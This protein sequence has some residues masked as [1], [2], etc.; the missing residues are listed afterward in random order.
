M[1]SKL[2]IAGLITFL[3]LIFG[4]SYWLP[5]TV[6]HKPVALNEPGNKPQ[7][8]SVN[9]PAFFEPNMGQHD[10]SVRFKA[11][12]S[13]GYSLFLTATEAVYV[14]PEQKQPD[15]QEKNLSTVTDAGPSKAA[16][17]WMKLDGADP[18]SRSEGVDELAGKTNYIL[19]GTHAVSRTNIPTYRGVRMENIYQGIDVVWRGIAANKVQYDFV[20]EPDADPRRIAWKVEGADSVSINE[21][22]DLL[23]ATEFGAI[24]QQKP[25][26]Y[27]ETEGV[28][29]EVASRFVLN[30]DSVGFE[31]GDYDRTKTLVI[32]PSVDLANAAFSTFLGGSSAESAR[33]VA[34]DKVGNVYVTGSTASSGFP[35]TSGVYD[36]SHNSNDDVFVT[37]LNRRADQ[38][39]YST[40]IGGS[41]LDLAHDIYL[42][43]SGSVIIAGWTQSSGYPTTGGAFDTSLGGTTDAFITKLNA[44]GTALVFSTFFGGN[45]L[46]EIKAV[47]ADSSGNIYVTG[48]TY[49][50]AAT[51]PLSGGAYQTTRIGEN[52][53]FVSK[54]NSSGTSLTYSTL[55]GGNAH[56]NGAND[57]VV[58]SSGNAYIVGSHLPDSTPF[59]TPFPTTGGAYDTTANGDIDAYV[60]KF[61]STGTAL[62]YS[63]LIGGSGF[64]VGRG[65]AL[66]AGSGEVV[67]TGY[68]EDSTTDFPVTGGA[69][70][71]GANGSVDGFVTRFNS[72][73]SSLVFS[74]FV[75][76]GKGEAVALDSEG[77][78]Y[79]TGAAFN[80]Y[81]TSL[82]PFDDTFGGGA[83][84]VAVSQ[85][86]SDGSDL[87]YSTFFGGN[88]TEG[89][90]DIALDTFGNTIVAGLTEG[91]NFPTIAGSYDTSFNGG[92]SDAVVLKL[93]C[94]CPKPIA[95]FDGDNKTD[96]SVFRPSNGNWY[97]SNPTSGSYNVA[98]GASG[99]IITPGDYDADGKADLAIFRPSTG[100][101]WV[102][103]SST[104]TYTATPWGSNGDIPVQADYDGDGK[105]DLAQWRP[106]NGDWYIVSSLT[107]GN[108]QTHFGTTGDVPAVGDYDGD[109]RSDLA[110]FRASD[111]NWYITNNYLG[112]YAFSWGTTGDKIAPADY[113]GDGRTDFAYYRPSTGYWWVYG[114]LNSSGYSVNWGASGAVPAPGDYDGDTKADINY[115]LPSDG[116]WYRINSSDNSQP[117]PVVLGTSGDI[118]IPSTYVR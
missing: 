39:I 44:D 18:N 62:T 53:A 81:P 102:Y 74:T 37:K 103:Y 111:T 104:A 43:P 3:S 33:G 89:G 24:R 15:I 101:W 14:V 36:T 68:T 87:S 65:I 112:Y 99:D 28:R 35:T 52:D 22:G 61:N 42:D 45:T 86:K 17:V 98:W 26:S 95:D 51:F 48:Y 9:I 67:I 57:I 30:K 10:A 107:G 47:T 49:S 7:P 117:T 88:N 90:L 118:P 75:G 19:G 108:S 116:K 20:V 69:F 70:D 16:A 73:A 55:L 63:T 66:D 21:E 59:P 50:S 92:S 105:T 54:L 58:D 27:Q 82:G 5:G 40:F 91:S 8:G 94:N 32:D 60:A 78:A 85:F 109:G 31:V 12:S 4:L 29:T 38:L 113:D 64:D 56:E 2:N 114:S 97:I 76:P 83:S 1:R 115:W 72:S 93:G 13:S 71:T 100:Y 41:S 77:N 106:S 23:I 34:V 46:E 6:G 84:D 96:L 25:Y 80:G 11:R 79:I 110:V